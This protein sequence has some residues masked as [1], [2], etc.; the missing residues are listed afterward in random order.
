MFVIEGPLDPESQLFVGRAAELAQMQQ[1]LSGVRCVGAVMGAR[2]TGKTSLLLKLRQ[3]LRGKY[4]FVFI[5]LE[6]VAHGDVAECVDYIASEM[7]AQIEDLAGAQLRVPRTAPEFL[8]FLEQCARATQHV[9]I[10]VLLDE[11]GALDEA[12]SLRLTSAIRAVFTSRLVKP[13]FARYVFVIAGST[14]MLDLAVGR[15]SPLRNV[16][17]TLYLGDLSATETERLLSVVLADRTSAG[18]DR[19]FERLHEWTHGHPYWTQ[20][21]GAALKLQFPACDESTI[22]LTVA[23]LLRTEDRNLPHLFRALEADPALADLVAAVVGGTPV[24]FSRANRAVARLELLGLLRNDDGRCAIRNRIYEEALVRQPL[25]FVQAP[26]RDLL[27]LVEH[28]FASNDVDTLLQA[29]ACDVQAVLRSRSTAVL[30]RRAPDAD[31]T[32]GAAV[33]VAAEVARDVRLHASGRLADALMTV[34]DPRRIELPAGEA[35]A[36]AAL[37]AA[38]VAP[39][40]LKGSNAVFLCVG[41][42]LSGAPFD[43]DDRDFI[44]TVG[45]QAAL[46]LERLD[47]RTLQ[48]DAQRA[49][50][51]QKELL[52]KDLP[53]VPGLQIV[54]SC[55]PARIV[56]GDYYDVLMLTDRTVAFCI[57]DVA[58][59]GMPAALLMASLQ[60]GVR[61][62]SSET[63]GPA[64]LCASLNRLL[65]QSVSPGEFITF[66]YAVIDTA[67]RQL[68]CTNA[69]HNPPILLRRTGELVRLEAGG[70]VLALFPHYIY[71]QQTV[72]LGDGDRLLMFTDGV[73]ETCN[74]ADEEFGDDRLIAIARQ[75]AG[76]GSM[77]RAVLDAV[78]RFGGG[79]FRDDVTV[80]AVTA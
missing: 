68:H 52:P 46:A 22:D 54:G 71:E 15:N 41:Q 5:D 48:R 4:C 74:A 26:A 7:I 34:V 59:K 11:I 8:Q 19:I 65:A 79:A 47:L 37:G 35:S 13:E 56:S 75:H 38:L 18:R 3:L 64:E 28:L 10:V 16:V 23:E 76:A 72:A 2:Q 55:Q 6:A 69:G 40:R 45:E 44:A 32:L 49:W 67:T 27:R 9:R 57:G 62:L 1:W 77:H 21:L 63:T 33:G 53:E 25:A 73:T 29:L 66:F 20:L 14:D 78:T 58:G 39:V 51:F 30:I 43:G 36:L 61:A 80:L 70:P 17:E 42:K 24:S 60:A 12:T 50:D 31:F